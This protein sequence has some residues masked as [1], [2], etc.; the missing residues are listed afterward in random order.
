MTSNKRS[1]TSRDPKAILAFMDE[2][3]SEGS[4]S[5]YN[6]YDED[7]LDMDDDVSDGSH[8]FCFPQPCSSTNFA[9]TNVCPG[10]LAISGEPLPDK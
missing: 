2:M 4:C 9:T 8:L 6:D 7:I 1:F 10:S 3:S 5:D